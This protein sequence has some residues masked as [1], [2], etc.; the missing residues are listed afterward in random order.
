MKSFHTIKNSV[1][2]QT[3]RNKFPKI[4]NFLEIIKKFSKNDDKNDP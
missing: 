1:H 4:P 2:K 3:A